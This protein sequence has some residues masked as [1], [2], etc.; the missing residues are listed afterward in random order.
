MTLGWGTLPSARG[1]ILSRVVDAFAGEFNEKVEQCFHA[2]PVVVIGFVA[3]GIVEGGGCLPVAFEATGGDL[4]VAPGCRSPHAIA[5][6]TAYETVGL[7]TVAEA[8]EGLA[9][10]QGDGDG[11]V[12]PYQADR[13]VLREQLAHLGFGFVFEI[14]GE[15][16][17]R[18]V[19]IPVVP[20]GVGVVPVLIL[21]IVEAESN[22]VFLA[23]F[24]EVCHNIFAV[25]RGIDNVVV[26]ARGVIHGKAVV[27]FGGDNE[28]F[29]TCIPR[30]FGNRI[31]VEFYWIELRGRVVRIPRREF[32]RGA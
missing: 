4:V 19:K 18:G 23:G 29:H 17:G 9:L 16:F 28:V 22:T 3:P 6:A 1:P 30:E 12:E 14:I 10:F 32:P 2:F 31:G 27:V 26:A 5:H 24:G 15:V 11:G 13:S 8:R 7:Q 21:R 25:R 20:R